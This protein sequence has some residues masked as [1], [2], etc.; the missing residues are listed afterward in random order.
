MSLFY[1]VQPSQIPIFWG[2]TR[3]LCAKKTF[4]VLYLLELIYPGKEYSRFLQ[5]E[6]DIQTIVVFAA[7]VGTAFMKVELKEQLFI[8]K[9]ISIR[10]WFLMH[11]R[12]QS[13]TRNIWR[14]THLT[15][16]Y[17]LFS[18]YANISLL[19]CKHPVSYQYYLLEFYN[20]NHF[21]YC[22]FN[23]IN[24]VTFC[25]VNFLCTLCCV[26]TTIFSKRLTKLT[27]LYEFDAH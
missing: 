13:N 20:R 21:T 3:L 23:S 25:L 22:Y 14:I 19:A 8:Y 17:A 1:Y 4:C 5:N 15:S 18:I 26:F 24:T 6:R 11:G 10:N 2:L 16:Q 9:A 27:N 7:F 12:V